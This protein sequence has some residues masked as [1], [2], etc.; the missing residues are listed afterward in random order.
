[1]SWRFDRVNDFVVVSVFRDKKTTSLNVI[2]VLY[3]T[4]QLTSDWVQ[5]CRH[6]ETHVTNSQLASCQQ[7]QCWV[8][9]RRASYVSVSRQRLTVP[10][11]Y[12][13]S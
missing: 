2:D 5:P 13:L 1:M 4:C 12:R 3:T 6:V 10:P 8:Y 9:R 11:R 7:L